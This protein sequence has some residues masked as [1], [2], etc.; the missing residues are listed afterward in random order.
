[1]KK[2][3][4]EEKQILIDAIDHYIDAGERARHILTGEIKDEHLQR[5]FK[6]KDLRAKLLLDC[7]PIEYLRTEDEGNKNIY[8][9]WYFYC[10]LCGETGRVSFPKNPVVADHYICGKCFE[11]YEPELYKKTWDIQH[12]REV[13]ETLDQLESEG[14][15][16]RIKIP[17]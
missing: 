5:L 9:K 4:I 1:M 8:D 17:E 6:I 7:N 2:F 3:T 10:F 12:S 11:K 16:K 15:V 13:E 14:I